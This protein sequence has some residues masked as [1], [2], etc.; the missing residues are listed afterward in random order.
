MLPLAP[1]SDY[2]IAKLLK[3][4]SYLELTMRYFA[5]IRPMGRL[6]SYL[7]LEIGAV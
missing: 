7:D 4:L 6:N 3:R 5:G 1:K 2:R